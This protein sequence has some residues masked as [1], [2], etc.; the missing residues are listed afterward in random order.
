MA[1]ASF[2]EPLG[3]DRYRATEH[4]VG[5]WDDRSQHGG[6]PAALLARALEDRAGGFEATVTRMSVDILGPVPVADVGVR[7]RVLRAGRSVEL[8]EAELDSGGHTVMRA[9][10]WRIR[11]A[12][13]ALP[14][15]AGPEGDVGEAPVPVFP[16]TPSPAGPG[17]GGGYLSAL[18][19]RPV[20]GRPFEPGPATIWARLRHPLVAGEEPSGLQRL[21]AVADSGNG[22]SSVLP[23]DGWLF[24]NTDLTVHLLAVPEGEWV[25][26]DARTRIDPAGFGLATSRLFDRRRLV[27]RGAQTLYVARR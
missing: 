10:A 20:D 16:E 7:T 19:W 1:S 22:V 6:P 14:P 2:Y 4:T 21:M 25:C 15:P 9:T 23:I 12:A 11:Q 3:G 24:V 13:L 5:P 18:E 17:W 27:A 26:L 8:L